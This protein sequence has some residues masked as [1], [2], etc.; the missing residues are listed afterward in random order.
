MEFE[1]DETKRLKNIEKHGLDFVDGYLVFED[2]QAVTFV[3]V[4]PS[5]NE[6]RE[7][8]IAKIKQTLIV[9]VVYTDRQ[10]IIR[11]IS[12]RLASKKERNLYYDNN[13]NVD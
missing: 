7:Y 12:F 2:P 5:N 6:I 10:G 4:K 13:K 8:T 9:M 11:I 3:S 1:W